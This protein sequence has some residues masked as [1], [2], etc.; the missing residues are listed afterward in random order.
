LNFGGDTVDVDYLEV[1]TKD[2]ATGELD[3]TSGKTFL[4]S[5]LTVGAGTGSGT[6]DVLGG[7]VQLGD[8]LFGGATSAV[9]LDMGQSIHVL[10]SNYSVSDAL[11]DI[12]AGHVVNYIEG[13]LVQVSTV[14]IGGV[15]YTQLMGTIPEPGTIAMLVSSVL[16]LLAYAWRK[17]K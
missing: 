13:G 16:G 11:A 6:V 10:Q 3:I 2:G 15:N 1:G 17:R 5:L 12:S 9:R 8:L 4:A 7:T 14:D